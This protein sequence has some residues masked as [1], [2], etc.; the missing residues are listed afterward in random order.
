MSD[1]T[2][3]EAPDDVMPGNGETDIEPE[4]EWENLDALLNGESTDLVAVDIEEPAAT[5][6]QSDA[7]PVAATSQD[8]DAARLTAS[9]ETLDLILQNPALIL[10]IPGAKDA[11]LGKL[12]VEAP[13]AAEEDAVD[14]DDYDSVARYV[15][16]QRDFLKEA[17][18]RIEQLQTSFQQS[19]LANTLVRV[20]Q[21]V[22]LEGVAT[23]LGL[24][25]PAPS[26]EQYNQMAVLVRGGKDIETAY[27]EV[28][29]K[30]FL[31]SLKTAK[32]TPKTLRQQTAV[33]A[34][35]QRV[36]KSKEEELLYRLKS[37]RR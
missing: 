5:T 16:K 20:Q 22:A 2:L 7:P 29:G 30:P 17:P 14:P 36:F 12:G 1:L 28:C 23:M 32:S 6:E 10:E 18:K 11:I 15:V 26:P 8:D 27:R 21:Q 37:V 4:A 9:K 31:D 13:V 35:R 25:I 34:D 3:G 24:S 33:N 19:E